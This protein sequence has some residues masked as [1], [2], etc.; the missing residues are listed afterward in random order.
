[1]ICTFH[2]FYCIVLG[3]LLYF[4]VN[5]CA[6]SGDLKYMVTGSDDATLKIWKVSESEILF[7]LKGHKGIQS[8]FSTELLD[9]IKSFSI[10]LP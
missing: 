4:K 6:F 8:I 5:C 9:Y 7:T 2:P 1:M 10:I 3:F